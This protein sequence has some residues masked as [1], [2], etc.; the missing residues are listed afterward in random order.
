MAQPESP[1]TG[2]VGGEA[3]FSGLVL[4]FGT[5]ALMHLGM[6]SDPAGGAKKTD[7]PQAKQVIDIL[8]LLKEKTSGNLLAEESRL[9][10]DLLFDLRMRYLEAMKQAGAPQG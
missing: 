5:T 10:E 6:V 7:L 2:N 3:T 9:L 4:M 8:E 1:S